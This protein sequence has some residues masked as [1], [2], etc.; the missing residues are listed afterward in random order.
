MLLEIGEPGLESIVAIRS[1]V[2]WSG[3]NK[4]DIQ[5]WPRLSCGLE[6]CYSKCEVQKH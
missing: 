3:E 4:Y 5:D 1:K 2:G 6:P